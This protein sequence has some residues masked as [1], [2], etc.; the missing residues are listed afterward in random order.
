MGA[1]VPLA[2]RQLPQ[3]GEQ[4]HHR[5][6]GHHGGLD[7]GRIRYPHALRDARGDAALDPGG[8]K[9]HPAQLARVAP[10]CFAVGWRADPIAG[11]QDLGVGDLVRQLLGRGDD[12]P[13]KLR[14][15]PRQPH[16]G[17]LPAERINHRLHRPPFSI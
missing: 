2:F 8:T 13:G 15:V 1:L 9:E 7:A 16:D 10:Q 5:M 17:V 3:Q 4:Q 12:R 14:K 11:H 6:L